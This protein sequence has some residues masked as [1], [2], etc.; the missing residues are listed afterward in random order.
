LSVLTDFELPVTLTKEEAARISGNI[1]DA[2]GSN[3][4]RLL[5]FMNTLVVNLTLAK[6]VKAQG[7]YILKDNL[8]LFVKLMLISYRFS[9]I[10]SAAREDAALLVRLQTCH[11]RYLGIENR[12]EGRNERETL[13]ATEL[14]LVR[15]LGAKE[16]F[17]R[18][19]AIA[20]QLNDHEDTVKEMMNWFRYRK[21]AGGTQG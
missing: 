13:L 21:P 12:Q 1:V 11:N 7:D 14:P 2:L 10:F 18:I 5:R 16:E 4:R 8:D 20:P 6:A 3:P 19:M 17:W 15:G 9:A